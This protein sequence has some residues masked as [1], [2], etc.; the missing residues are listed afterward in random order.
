MEHT[1]RIQISRPAHAL[2]KNFIQRKEMWSILAI[3]N[4]NLRFD[5]QLQPIAIADLPP[6]EGLLVTDTGNEGLQINSQPIETGLLKG[7]VEDIFVSQI[8]DL[9]QVSVI[10]TSSVLEVVPCPK[11]F[12]CS[13]PE[14]RTLL[15]N[16]F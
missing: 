7:C 13:S 3:C 5:I 12:F 11:L 14:I 6:V 9:G 8:L 15:A 16:W 10:D 2:F 4:E 1:T